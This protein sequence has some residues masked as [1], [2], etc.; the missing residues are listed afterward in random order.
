MPN[1]QLVR[2]QSRYLAPARAARRVMP[3][4]IPI[5]S[6]YGR[7][8]VKYAATTIQ[9]AWRSSRNKGTKNI[10]DAKRSSVRSKAKWSVNGTTKSRMRPYRKVSKSLYQKG[11]CINWEDNGLIEDLNCVWVGHHT[12]PQMYTLY[13]AVNAIVK[14]LFQRNNQYVGKL[15]EQVISNGS[16]QFSGYLNNQQLSA[17]TVIN[18]PY[19]NGDSFRLIS[20]NVYNSL[21]EFFFNNQTGSLRT[22]GDLPSE[23]YPPNEI[24]LTTAY[25][26]YHIESDLKVQN[27]TPGEF[28]SSNDESIYRNPLQGKIYNCRG[29]GTQLKGER[30]RALMADT[31]GGRISVSALNIS[32]L[33]EPPKAQ[34]FSSVKKATNVQLGP[35]EIK[36][37][38]LFENRKIG[39]NKLFRS[40]ND[41]RQLYDVTND[42]NPGANRA[43][44][45][46]V[47]GKSTLLG[48]EKKMNVSVGEVQQNIG[49]FY[50]HN[51]K[52][53]CE[54]IYR[55]NAVT[56]PIHINQT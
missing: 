56:N 5:A 11:V 41:Y 52:G 25:F 47:P 10:K 12:M 1:R 28:G 20:G 8:A 40:Y 17:S 27:V 37:T 22:V 19:T 48:L 50:E 4:V 3:Y 36:S 32:A 26:N 34:A 7:Q 16:I 49:I 21:I 51:W 23:I 45:W 15:S 9:K 35:G 14:K 46:H 31:W 33:Q 13:I 42:K 30:D 18:Q 29:A 6:K 53:V 2:Y 44:Q 38:V 39:F 43:N 54:F 55:Q 24:Q